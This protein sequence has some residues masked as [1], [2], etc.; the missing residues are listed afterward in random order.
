MPRELVQ[1]SKLPRLHQQWYVG[2]AAVFW[3]FCTVERSHGWFRPGFHDAWRFALLHACARF[4]L[5]C[6]GYVLMQD[7]VH[8]V[9]MGLSNGSDQ[10]RA[11]KFIREHTAPALAPACWQKQAH[12]RVLRQEQRKRGAFAAAVGY[13]LENPVRAGFAASPGEYPFVGCCVPGYPRLHPCSERYWEIFWR[14]RENAMNR[15][16]E[17]TLAATTEGT[18]CLAR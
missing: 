1:R 13:V 12:D 3:T 2:E 9:L 8:L 16:H 10:L 5:V 11:T 4:G 18:G 14:A 6:P 17:L 15:I 7:H